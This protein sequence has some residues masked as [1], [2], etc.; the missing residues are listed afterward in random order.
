MMGGER[1][2]KDGRNRG[3]GTIGGRLEVSTKYTRS[4]IHRKAEIIRRETRIIRREARLTHRKAS[5]NSGKPSFD[6]P[7]TDNPTGS[8]VNTPQSFA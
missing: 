8:R 5:L 1:G 2:V 7:N 4:L 6:D 3:G